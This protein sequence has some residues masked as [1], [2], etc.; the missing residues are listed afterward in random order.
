[1]RMYMLLGAIAGFVA[2]LVAGLGAGNTWPVVF[3]HASACALLLGLAARWWGSVW[4]SSF[5]NALIEQAARMEAQRKEN[6]PSP[7]QVKP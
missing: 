5:R 2:G 6:Q 7:T 1:M 4:Q 3:W